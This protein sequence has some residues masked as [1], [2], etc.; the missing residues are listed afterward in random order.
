MTKALTK[1]EARRIKRERRDMLKA[2][3]IL[4]QPSGA[5]WQPGPSERERDAMRTVLSRR[6][7]FAGLDD[8][9]DNRRLMKDWDHGS[10]IGRLFL[11]GALRT[12][13]EPQEAAIRRKEAAFA[14]AMLD[15]RHRSVQGWP[16]RHARGASYGQIAGLGSGPSEE[17]I[18]ALRAA[19]S[20]AHR[21]SQQMGV[22]A[23]DMV[24]SVVMRDLD[25]PPT[26][27]ALRAL[28]RGLDVMAD[29][30]GR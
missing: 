15:A 21:A 10:A 30:F 27:N 28:R 24:E 18:C 25:I 17:T 8:T 9:D 22:I 7:R 26:E 12:E 13:S 1:G 2:E 29:H 5:K 20:A 16:S 6:C 23:R 11:A 4:R 19:Y 14:F 3:G